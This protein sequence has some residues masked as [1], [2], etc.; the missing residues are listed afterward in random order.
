MD[1][2]FCQII[3]ERI[4][5]LRENAHFIVILDQY[6]VNEGHTL[7]IAKRHIKYISELVKQEYTSLIDIL[8]KAKTLI[9]H[10]YTPDGFNVGINEGVVAGQTVEHLH[11]HIIPRYIGDVEDPEGGIRNVIPGKGKYS[12]KRTLNHEKG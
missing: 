10:E 3:K 8:I 11:V 1:C 2:E 6:P 4:S 7:I 5:I 9:E 12:N